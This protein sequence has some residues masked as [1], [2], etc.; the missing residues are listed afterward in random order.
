VRHNLFNYR[1]VIVAWD[2][3]PCVD[4]S[5]WD[6]VKATASGSNQPFYMLATDRFF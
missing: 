5:N 2:R 3:R 4:V 6:G 1:G